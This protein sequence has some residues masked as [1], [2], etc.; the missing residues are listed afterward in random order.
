MPSI[1]RATWVWSPS[2]LEIGSLKSAFQRLPLG[3]HLLLEGLHLAEELLQ[4]SIRPAHAWD[5]QTAQ[6]S[7]QPAAQKLL[8]HND[9]GVMLA[10]VYLNNMAK[11]I[12]GLVPSPFDEESQ[13]SLE[14]FVDSQTKD[15]E[16]EPIFE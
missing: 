7:Q 14:V 11:H 4:A 3:Q 13:K 16:Y 5:R 9:F 2:S 12:H 6:V 8:E 15:K 10:R 1:T